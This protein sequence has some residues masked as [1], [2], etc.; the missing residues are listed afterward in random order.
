MLD[1]HDNAVEY[2][3]VSAETLRD[4]AAA[5]AELREQC[6]VHHHVGLEHPM[7]T[8]S[9][10]DD[11]Q[12]VLTDQATWS[13]RY[14]PG[15]SYGDDNIGD[16]QRYDPPEHQ[17][18]R[19]FLRQRFLPRAIE[20]SAPAVRSLANELVDELESRSRAAELSQE[21]AMPLPVRGFTDLMGIS[22]DEAGDF[23]AWADDLTLGM[24]YPDK[25]R[26]ARQSMSAWTRAQV[27][28]R[29]DRGP[30]GRSGSGLLDHLACDR[31]EDGSQLPDLEVAGMV[32][33]LLVA[34]HETTTSLITN[35]VWRLLEAPERWR[36]LLAEPELVPN[37]IEESLRFDPPV[38]GLCK[39]NNE[40]V[41]RH[42]VDIDTDAKVM[43]LYAS[44]NRDADHFA[45]PDEFLLDRPLIETKRHLSFGWG[46]HFCLGSHLAR[47]TGR[48]ALET[49][50]ERLPTLALAEPQRVAADRI[51]AP[52]LWG[53]SRLDVTW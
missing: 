50:L 51:E 52:F 36:R 5:Y 28:A 40:P 31:L 27:A 38:L 35:A 43:I 13:N 39:T 49:L 32:G 41:S 3:P 47:L 37:V 16:L 53:R 10:R 1:P 34:G 29:R 8:F 33:Q 17:R 22:D 2:D 21:F 18:R 25:A 4:P 48:I 26:S 42:G 14:G 44:A 11:V 6:P 15:I 30:T 20:A 46:A 19:R 7:Y 9:R 23:K 12:W 45:Q 24:T